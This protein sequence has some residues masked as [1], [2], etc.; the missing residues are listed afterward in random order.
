MSEMIPDMARYMSTILKANTEALKRLLADKAELESEIA[1]LRDFI[2]M[3]DIDQ[4]QGMFNHYMEMQ[5]Q[6]F[7]GQRDKI[8]VNFWRERTRKQMEI[9]E[10]FKTLAPK[11]TPNEDP[12]T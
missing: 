1:E 11:E 12:Q 6:A 5:K 2:S 10:A 8:T 7:H 9:I 3:F 4:L